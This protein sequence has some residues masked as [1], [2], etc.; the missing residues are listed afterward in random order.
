MC[1]RHG[2]SLGF[3]ASGEWFIVLEAVR[4]PKIIVKAALHVGN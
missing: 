3:R 4:V 1:V 2:K